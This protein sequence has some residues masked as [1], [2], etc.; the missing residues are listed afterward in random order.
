M[1]PTD[2]LRL[3][4]MASLT[5]ALI[6]AGVSDI[7]SRKIPNVTVLVVLGLYVAWA[8]V[9]KG[10]GLAPALIAAAIVFVVTVSLYA[11][12]VM[13][14]G[15][16]KLFS[17][18][19]LFAGLEHLPILVLATALTG[20]LMGVVSL[21]SRPTRALVMLTLRGKGDYGRGIPYGVAIAAGGSLTIWIIMGTIM[22]LPWSGFV[23]QGLAPLAL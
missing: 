1:T 4:I 12:N 22:A 19:A 23:R 2:V 11:F 16:A 17:A 7:R 9:N 6:W 10:V 18:V 5:G 15:D 8:A 14:A 13:G 3:G 20:G 21:A